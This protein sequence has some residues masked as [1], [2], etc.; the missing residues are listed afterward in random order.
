[1]LMLVM[2]DRQGNPGLAGPTG[3]DGL[4]GSRGMR[5]SPGP[6]GSPGEDGEKGEM[7]MPGEKGHQ[8]KLGEAVRRYSTTPCA[9]VYLV[10]CLSC[11]NSHGN[12]HK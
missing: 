3:R 7:G 11:L 10:G 4:P 6:I 12:V 9:P 1:M 8:G 5:G 2:P